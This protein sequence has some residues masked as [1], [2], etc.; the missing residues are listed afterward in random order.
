MYGTTIDKVL[1]GKKINKIFFSK[2]FLRFSTDYGDFTYEVE[3]DCCSH[4]EF[5]D[6]YGV[7]KLLESGPVTQVAEV[8]LERG[9]TRPDGDDESTQYYGYKIVA[10]HPM[11]GEITAVFSFRNMSNGF[12]GGSLA[13]S[14]NNKEILPEVTDDVI[15]AQE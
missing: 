14:M 11:W 5:W 8:E 4:S 9:N 1:T 13:D 3:G 12:Y 7:T 10:E 6:F 15:E 2:Q